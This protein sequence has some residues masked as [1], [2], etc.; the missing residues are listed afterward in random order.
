MPKIVRKNTLTSEKV[1]IEDAYELF[2]SSRKTSCT[3]KTYRIYD[4]VGKRHII[5]SL[6]S[7]T[8]G[9]MDDVNAVV[10]R[11][12]INDYASEHTNGGKWFYYRHLKVY[13]N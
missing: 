10:L 13:I 6:L 4:E 2:L 8:D 5:P 1:K 12:S 7:L 9:Y 3:S 11:A